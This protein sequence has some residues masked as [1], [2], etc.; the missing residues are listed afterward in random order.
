M[1]KRYNFNIQK[2]MKKG[3]IIYYKEVSR[4]CRLGWKGGRRTNNRRFQE[5]TK[6]RKVIT[7]LSR[8]KIIPFSL[9]LRGCV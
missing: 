5:V 9:H 3:D 8:R 6:T 1:Q 7:K 4:D 2:S